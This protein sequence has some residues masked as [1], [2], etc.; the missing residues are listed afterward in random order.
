[1][2]VLRARYLAGAAALAVACFTPTAASAQAC[3]IFGSPLPPPCIVIDASKVAQQAAEI[4]AKADEIREMA[5]KAKEMTSIQGAL[6]AVTDKPVGMI[7]SIEPIAPIGPTTANEAI[8]TFKATIPQS[9]STQSGRGAFNTELEEAVRGAGGDGW[10]I[11]QVAKGRL[12]NLANEARKIQAFASC[13]ARRKAAPDGDDNANLRTDWQIRNRAETLMLQSMALMQEVEAARLNANSVS[14]LGEEGPSKAPDMQRSNAPDIPK[15]NN[16]QWGPK[17]ATVANLATKLAALYAAKKVIDG[18]LGA[19]ANHRETQREYEQVLEKARNADRELQNLAVREARKKGK[20][21]A[22]LMNKVNQVMSQDRTAW[23]DPAKGPI[24]ERLAKSAKGQL[25]NMVKGDVSKDWVNTI[26]DRSDA[27]K[28]EAFF[29]PISEDSKKLDKELDQ[30]ISEYEKSIG[31]KASD[32][33]AL[34]AAIAETE[35]QL[36]T[37]G[38]ELKSAP[39]DII[40]QRDQIYNS[41]VQMAA[42]T[43]D[44]PSPANEAARMTTPGA[45]QPLDQGQ[46]SNN[47]TP[48]PARSKANTT[49]GLKYQQF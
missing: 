6:G 24:T 1:M 4:K 44:D 42:P 9:N 32:S 17:L 29:R 22:F 30:W 26:I 31:V 20:S 45:S 18:F 43:F 13:N 28:E 7:D 38:T 12:T 36:A 15:S 47:S 16:P 11:A 3:L 49:P 37:V 35:S 39:A 14:V 27:Y 40:R 25:D 21:A 33:A 19:K 10:S 41:T 34:Q 8:Y 48:T 46:P 23:D 5:N 2:T